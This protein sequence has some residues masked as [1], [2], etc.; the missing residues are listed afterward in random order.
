MVLWF[1][2]GRNLALVRH[3]RVGRERAWLCID[4]CGWTSSLSQGT[5]QTPRH[6]RSRVR[7]KHIKHTRQHFWFLSF[8]PSSP[9][10]P[11]QRSNA[12]YV[13]LTMMMYILDASLP[14]SPLPCPQKAP[15]EFF[16]FFSLFPKPPLPLASSVA[17]PSKRSTS[18]ER[19]AS[20][21]AIVPRNQNGPP[22]K[23]DSKSRNVHYQ[24]GH[25]TR[26]LS[27]KENERD[28]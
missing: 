7:N 4:L 1:A 15:R 18:V 27:P 20:Q 21:P 3:A 2:E 26:P 8:R 12:T 24:R 17:P 16:A 6:C 10:T 23:E 28:S 5:R 25:L 19:C 14:T 11:G 22:E 9:N 13:S